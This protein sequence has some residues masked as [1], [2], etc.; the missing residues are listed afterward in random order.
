ML[1]LLESQVDS[2]GLRT[3]QTKRWLSRH[4]V[5]AHIDASLHCDMRAKT[6]DD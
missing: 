3:P 2:V 5:G 1:V 4:V 6:A